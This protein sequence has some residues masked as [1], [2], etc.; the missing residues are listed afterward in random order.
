MAVEKPVLDTSSV[1]FREDV[2]NILPCFCPLI[3]KKKLDL[4]VES[5]SQDDSVVAKAYFVPKCIEVGRRT[6]APTNQNRRIVPPRADI[7]V[8]CLAFTVPIFLKRSHLAHNMD[9]FFNEEVLKNSCASDVV[10]TRKREKRL[11]MVQSMKNK[12]KK[13]DNLNAVIDKIKLRNSL[14]SFISTENVLNVKFGNLPLLP[15]GEFVTFTFSRFLS[16]TLFPKKVIV[17]AFAFGVNSETGNVIFEDLICRFE[18]SGYR[19]LCLRTIAEYILPKPDFEEL[20]EM[21][22]RRKKLSSSSSSSSSSTPVRAFGS[23]RI[24]KKNTTREFHESHWDVDYGARGVNIL[25]ESTLKSNK[26]PVSKKELTE[27]LQNLTNKAELTHKTDRG[28]SIFVE[29]QNTAGFGHFD[30]KQVK[31]GLIESPRKSRRIFLSNSDEDDKTGEI[32]YDFSSCNNVDCNFVVSKGLIELPKT[33]NT[34]N[35]FFS[36]FD[37]EKSGKI[38]A[39]K[40]GRSRSYV[41]VF[42]RKTL[43]SLPL[44]KFHLIH[45]YPSLEFT[46]FDSSIRISFD[47]KKIKSSLQKLKAEKTEVLIHNSLATDLVSKAVD[48]SNALQ[49]NDFVYSEPP[50][51]TYPGLKRIEMNYEMLENWMRRNLIEFSDLEPQESEFYVLWNQFIIKAENRL[52]NLASLFDVLFIIKAENRPTNLASLFDVLM[53]FIQKYHKEI[54]ERGLRRV[55]LTFVVH[56]R[57][58]KQL[59]EFEFM[60]AT[61]FGTEIE[62]K[63]ETKQLT[64]FE[65]MEATTFGTEIESKWFGRDNLRPSTVVEKG[66]PGRRK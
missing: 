22:L 31:R 28:H 44:L 63:W 38:L 58:T 30:K 21:G 27:Q 56:L 41:C 7:P 9:E 11:A 45:S 66:K 8:I 14:K 46:F 64:E 42:C 4:P 25:D 57:E 1:S 37:D 19:K 52:T 6:N 23:L 35:R 59:T 48:R 15:S 51:T 62:S 47:R 34:A 3:K 61:T 33:Y 5:V 16:S 32:I 2:E 12:N 40:S 43:T 55:F 18:T 53:R 60:E 49:V 50:G 10:Q 29:L 24:A 36:L 39:H 26:L 20:N 65:F 13:C 17:N 54:E